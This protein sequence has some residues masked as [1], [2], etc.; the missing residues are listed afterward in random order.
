M[1]WNIRRFFKLK[2]MG[3]NQYIHIRHSIILLMIS[4]IC[5][6]A[7]HNGWLKGQL[8]TLMLPVVSVN[9][10]YIEHSADESRDI[11]VVLAALNGGL[12]V[13]QSSSI[14]ISFFVDV[15][16]TLGNTL[17]SLNDLVISARN[18]SMKS[19]AMLYTTKLILKVCQKIYYSFLMSAVIFCLIFMGCR[20]YMSE[21]T[22]IG[23][24]FA[25]LSKR[26]FSLF[27]LSYLLIPLSIH[28]AGY[29]SKN[30][31]TL[32]RA[33]LHGNYS[34]IHKH[35]VGDQQE[36]SLKK[37]AEN[38]I[39]KFENIM[40]KLDHKVEAMTMNVVSHIAVVVF[41]G[42]IVPLA[43][44]AILLWL[45]HAFSAHVGETFSPFIKKIGLAKS[46]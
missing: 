7:F 16:I 37:R 1:S 9:E 22:G 42:L 5:I 21:H 27:L 23:K 18:T 13:L 24:I 35:I 10:T 8:D 45:Y 39:H 15:D 30:I 6:T 43:M 40:T 25:K 29:I 44:L 41:D 17:S 46:V 38:A 4:L 33:E 2:T 11:L 34:N 26:L 14:G 3:I 12:E 31:S 19:I 20:V 28:G 32:F 36:N